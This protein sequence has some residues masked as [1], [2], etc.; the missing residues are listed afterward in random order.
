M[1]FWLAGLIAA[2]LLGSQPQAAQAPEQSV[3][4]FAAHLQRGLPQGFDGFRLVAA[5]AEGSL[6]VFTADGGRG[7]RQRKSNAELTREI[8]EGFCSDGRNFLTTLNGG[9]IRVD[10]L[11]DGSALERGAV[12]SDCP[13]TTGG[14]NVG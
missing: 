4:G 10:T 12:M 13:A 5:R 2:L 1:V 3:A 11:E 6:L 9:G 8:M 7:W 14:G